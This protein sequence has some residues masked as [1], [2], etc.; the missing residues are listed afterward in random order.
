MSATTEPAQDVLERTREAAHPGCI[1]CGPDNGGG[2]G[3][4]FALGG[5][6]SVEASLDC[7]P[8]LQGYAGMLHGG[9]TSTLL[10][11][12]MTNCLFAHGI[13]AVTAELTV[14]FRHPVALDAPLAVRAEIVRSQ[15]PL[16]VLQ[17][18]IVQGGQVKAKA[19]GKFIERR[20][21]PW[22]S[23]GVTA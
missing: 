5:D 8:H 16:H 12:A 23:T 14:R 1:A 15:E 3:L 22:S 7:A 17:A 13:V 10:D 21:E 11:S 18:R 9:V 2:L 19:T 20:H 6:G 4:R